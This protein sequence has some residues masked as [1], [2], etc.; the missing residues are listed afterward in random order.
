MR[1]RYLKYT[2]NHMHCIA[3]FYGEC[4]AHVMS[5]D[6]SNAGP[7]VP[8]GTGLVSV[9]SLD[10]YKDVSVSVIIICIGTFHY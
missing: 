7:V 8:P 5:C 9:T 3:T 1:Y 6:P 10:D 2:P 4:S